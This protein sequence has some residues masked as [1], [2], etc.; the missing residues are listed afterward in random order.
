MTTYG[1]AAVPKLERPEHRR[2]PHRARGRLISAATAC[3]QDDLFGGSAHTLPSLV[4]RA[5]TGWAFCAVASFAARARA[6]GTSGHRPNRLLRRVESVTTLLS[7][8][9]TAG[10]LVVDYGTLNPALQA[11]QSR[12]CLGHLSCRRVG[13]RSRAETFLLGT[14]PHACVAVDMVVVVYVRVRSPSDMTMR[15]A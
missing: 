6:S 15:R 4:A 3:A 12:N 2:I 13:T 14:A 10:A 9:R 5:R 11:T 1:S 7:R 8:C